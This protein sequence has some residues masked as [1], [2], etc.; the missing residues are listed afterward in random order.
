MKLVEHYDF[1]T[2]VI[3]GKRY[4]RD[5]IVTP[6]RVIE[7]WWRREG[8]RVCLEDI[9]DLLSEDIEYLVIGTG[10]SGLVEVDEEVVKEFNKRGV[11]VVIKPSRE[12]IE[13]YNR[14]VRDGKKVALAIHLTC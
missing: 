8:H 5:L 13:E 1:G 10:Y 12:A 4:F 6:T 11:K 9:R 2:I 3:G 7:N 14:L